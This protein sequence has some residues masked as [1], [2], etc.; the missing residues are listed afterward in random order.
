M[1]SPLVCS[2]QSR[3]VTLTL[4]AYCSDCCVLSNSAAPFDIAAGESIKLVST[5]VFGQPRVL[6][7]KDNFTITNLV[8]Q[9]LQIAG[10]ARLDSEVLDCRALFATYE[11][12]PI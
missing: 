4:G 10:P 11:I 7:K 8:T 1:V 6:V 5:Y 3:F 9:S 12:T 2:A